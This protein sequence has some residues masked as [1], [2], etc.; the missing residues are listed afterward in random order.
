[1]QNKLIII[2][3]ISDQNCLLNHLDASTDILAMSPSVMLSL[4]GLDICY[5]TTDDFYH[6]DTY[7]SDIEKFNEETE[8]ILST[9][10]EICE[11]IV[12]F[13]Y[14]YSGNASYF[15]TWFADILYL[16]KLIQKIR[17]QY[18]KIVLVS[19]S[20]PQIMSWKGL[21]YSDLQSKHGSGTIAFPLLDNLE[22]KIESVLM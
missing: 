6:T 11:P 19:H 20:I 10:D 21:K 16:E 7:I 8:N 13:P 5:K 18:Q 1:M 9:L 2:E 22:N 14:A 17:T 15:M 12:N 4:D 3:S